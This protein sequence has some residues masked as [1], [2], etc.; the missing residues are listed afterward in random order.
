MISVPTNKGGNMVTILIV[1]DERAQRI[2]YKEEISDLGHRVILARDGNDALRKMETR[3]PDLI[4]LDIMMPGMNGLETL[5]KKL[6][7]CPAIPVII[8]SAYSHFETD[9][10]SWSAEEYVVKSS[11]LTHLK[12]AIKRALSHW[13]FTEVSQTSEELP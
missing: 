12:N 8:H 1:E 7:S 3:Q 4:I 10:R 2:L 5:Q 9:P 6:E 11:D 13:S